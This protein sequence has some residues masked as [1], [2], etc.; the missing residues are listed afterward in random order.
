M[1]ILPHVIRIK[2]PADERVTF[3]DMIRGHVSFETNQVDDKVLAESRWHANVPF[4]RC[5]G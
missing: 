5:G 4:G 2:M 3:N 1:P